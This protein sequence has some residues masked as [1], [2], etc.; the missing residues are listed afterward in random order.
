LADKRGLPILELGGTKRFGDAAERHQIIVALA[1]YGIQSPAEDLDWLQHR[2]GRLWRWNAIGAIG[3]LLETT[4]KPHG[5][6]LQHLIQ[7]VPLLRALSDCKGFDSVLARWITPSEFDGTEFELVSAGFCLTRMPPHSISFGEAVEV[8]GHLKRP[9]IRLE[10]QGVTTWVECKRLDPLPPRPK[11]RV[12]ALA[13]LFNAALER[14]QLPLPPAPVDLYVQLGD[15]ESGERLARNLGQAAT[16]SI[17]QLGWASLVGKAVTE[18]GEIQSTTEP[19]SWKSTV[20]RH[21]ERPANFHPTPKTMIGVHF[22]MRSNSSPPHRIRSMISDALTQLPQGQPRIVCIATPN[23]IKLAETVHQ[24]MQTSTAA[25]ETGVLLVDN[26]SG[27]MMFN[28]RFT[29]PA[30]IERFGHP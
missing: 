22:A 8:R 29:H 15:G 23:A 14:D 20:I 5:L 21:G 27:A 17:R 24:W 4:G 28:A 3:Q 16:R 30:L 11:N 26:P 10:I 6:F 7:R 13:L 25:P 12:N 19:F 9:D 18:T 2:L 1:A